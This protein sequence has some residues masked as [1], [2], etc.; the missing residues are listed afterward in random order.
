VFALL[1][2]GNLYYI[3]LNY[4]Y[5][6]FKHLISQ[7]YIYTDSLDKL[8]EKELKRDIDGRYYK[9]FDNLVISIV[10]R[11]IRQE[12]NDRYTYQYLPEQY[13]K[14]KENEK[15]EAEKSSI[16]V[17]GDNI[18][19]LKITNYSKHTKKF[20]KQQK[21]TLEKYPNIIID[22]RDNP[23]G[24]VAVLNYM[25]G[26]FLPED[27][28][29]SYDNTRS[30]LFT[31]TV[32]SKNKQELIYD[33]III[34]QDNNTASSAE[35]FIA[36]LK[37]NL[38]NV[39]LIGD[40]SYGKGTGQLTMKLKNDFAVKATVMLWNTPKNNNI[41]G[42]GIEPDIKYNNEDI[43]DYAVKYINEK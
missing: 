15:K 12:Q 25:S 17:L 3:Y 31:K 37:D 9:Y 35:G 42:T 5:L 29:I 23:G 13:K 21:D 38:D 1:I 7:N 36:A 24:D 33:N 28:I 34:L 18:V 43:I 11:E 22:L 14:S 27:K 30:K 20:M 39:V 26:L 19:Y 10:T 41:Q 8:Y 40:T 6:V 2:L 16:D 32:K 4:D